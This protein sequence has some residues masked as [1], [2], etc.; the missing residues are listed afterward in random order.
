ME[1]RFMLLL[2]LLNIHLD[3]RMGLGSS[4]WSDLIQIFKAPSS[5]LTTS[6]VSKL[7]N[8]QLHNLTASIL[9]ESLLIFTG[10]IPGRE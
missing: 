9:T 3:K 10:A 5:N 2:G 7:Q 8:S 6:R 1:L 4:K